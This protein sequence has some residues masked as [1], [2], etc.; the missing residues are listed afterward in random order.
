MNNK[1]IIL[2]IQA[3]SRREDNCVF[4]STAGGDRYGFGGGIQY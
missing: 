3:E 2:C 4:L 1:A